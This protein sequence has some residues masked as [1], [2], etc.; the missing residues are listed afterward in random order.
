MTT[1]AFAGAITTKS[2]RCGRYTF[3][4]RLPRLGSSDD[5]EQWRVSIDGD[6]LPA[7]YPSLEHAMAAALEK[8][9]SP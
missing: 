5:I 3:T 9:W 2:Y 1:S 6:E 4:A 7:T 8:S